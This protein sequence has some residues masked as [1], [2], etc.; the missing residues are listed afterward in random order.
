[1]DI[2]WAHAGTTGCMWLI[3]GSQLQLSLSHTL[4]VR[5]CL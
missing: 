5:T 3:S 4:N 1:M 2:L